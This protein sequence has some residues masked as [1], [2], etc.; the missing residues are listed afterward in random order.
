MHGA[1]C[2]EE[3]CQLAF[4]I[5]AGGDQGS[6][7]TE[8]RRPNNPADAEVLTLHDDEPAAG[9]QEPGHVDLAGLVLRPAVVELGETGRSAVSPDRDEWR[10]SALFYLHSC[11]CKAKRRFRALASVR[12]TFRVAE[13]RPTA[14]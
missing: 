14:I 11:R 6:G 9:G 8:R 10:V 2:R 3:S 5:A 12:H 7:E 4:G 13:K 1:F